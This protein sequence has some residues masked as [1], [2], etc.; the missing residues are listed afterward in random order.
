MDSN[1]TQK[2]ETEI[3]LRDAFNYILFKGW[4]V[5][6]VTIFAVIIS[7]IYTNLLLTELYI[8]EAKIFITNES[9][10][11]VP[12]SSSDIDW[13]LSKQYSLSAEEFITED[14]CQIIAN[15]LNNKNLE[16]GEEP[17]DCSKFIQGKSFKQYFLEVTGNSE[18]TPEYILDCISISTNSNTCTMS[19]SASTT[20]PALS[21]IITNAIADSFEDHLVKILETDEV[22]AKVYNSGK[23]ASEPYNIAT[24][25]N[26]IIGAL[27]GVILSCGVLFLV[28]IFDDKIK[29]PEDVEKYLGL[30]VLGAIPELEKEI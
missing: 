19:V 25:R 9:D 2:R 22:K 16:P 11:G 26:V 20:D 8:S 23:V 10:S 17:Y 6:L 12:N 4:I 3:N 28:F 1:N 24:T 27:I 15:K 14:Y 7:F 13:T 5:I 29:S 21:A 18:I 30:S